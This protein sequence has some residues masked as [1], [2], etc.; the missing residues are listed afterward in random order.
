MTKRR[1][2][3][4]NLRRSKAAVKAWVTRTRKE[5]L[6]QVVMAAASSVSDIYSK[7][8]TIKDVAIG[9]IKITSPRTY[10]KSRVLKRLD[11]L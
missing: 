10:R 4:K 3:I 1:K 11:K 6:R 7:V 8:K 9:L 2:K 5:G